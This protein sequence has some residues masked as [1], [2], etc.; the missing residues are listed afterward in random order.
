MPKTV[1]SRVSFVVRI[2][3]CKI[4]IFGMRRRLSTLPAVELPREIISLE[5][6]P[7][8]LYSFYQDSY[9]ISLTPADRLVGVFGAT[10][11]LP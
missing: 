1:T 4:F 2:H 5:V 9:Y 11:E 3:D 7:G 8:S 10:L 6:E